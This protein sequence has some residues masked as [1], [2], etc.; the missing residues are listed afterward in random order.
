MKQE[1]L[2]PDSDS[3]TRLWYDATKAHSGRLKPGL[4]QV[5]VV[6]DIHAQTACETHTNLPA[7]RLSYT[8]T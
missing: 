1:D 5:S 6:R 2:L 3:F 7:F 4:E 8:W